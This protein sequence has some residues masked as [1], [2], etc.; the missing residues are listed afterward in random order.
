MHADACFPLMDLESI[1][2][3]RRGGCACGKLRLP[4]KA[5]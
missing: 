2:S 5:G 4:E 3:W 1:V